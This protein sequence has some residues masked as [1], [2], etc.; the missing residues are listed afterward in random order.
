MPYLKKT[1]ETKNRL[2][3]QKHN[4]SRIMIYFHLKHDKLICL[5]AQVKQGI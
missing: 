3:N 5:I 1:D 2:L 4:Y